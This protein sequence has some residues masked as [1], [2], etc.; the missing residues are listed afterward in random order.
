MV[1]IENT[2][3]R[4]KLSRRS[5]RYEFDSLL[6]RGLLR[7]RERSSQELSLYVSQLRFDGLS[8]FDFFE[9]IVRQAVVGVCEWPREVA[10]RKL[11]WSRWD[12]QSQSSI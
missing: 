5:C 12:E 6:V 10:S 2:G 7:L 9:T 4:G 1:R 11:Q 8:N 3:F